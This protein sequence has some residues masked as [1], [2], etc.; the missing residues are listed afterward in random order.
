MPS[1][2]RLASQNSTVIASNLS[3]WA[4][5]VNALAGAWKTFL[6]H[7]QPCE[8]SCSLFSGFDGTPTLHVAHPPTE[9]PPPAISRSHLIMMD[10]PPDIKSDS[11]S[12]LSYKDT[13]TDHSTVLSVPPPLTPHHEDCS[14]NAVQL[15]CPTTHSYF[16]HWHFAMTAPVTPHSP[17]SIGGIP[18]IHRMKLHL[19]GI[20]LMKFDLAMLLANLPQ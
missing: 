20:R 4:H 16:L 11:D 9:L 1:L 15:L 17:T 8:V 6:Q 2:L 5:R 12:S 10:L 18:Q 3:E 13:T 14:S 7:K 19:A